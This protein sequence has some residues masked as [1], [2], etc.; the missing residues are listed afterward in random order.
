MVEAAWNASG[1]DASTWS[2]YS[3]TNYYDFYAAAPSRVT[4]GTLPDLYGL[5]IAA[6]AQTNVTNPW[7]IYQAGAS[8]NNFLAGPLMMQKDGAN[9]TAPGAGNIRF[10]VVCGTNAGTAKIQVIGGT[11]TT[12]QTLLD[13]IGSGVSGC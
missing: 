3:P 7:G 6:M 2:S 4:G 10:Q 11:S 13:N 9:T 12:P 5:Y 8:D 1:I